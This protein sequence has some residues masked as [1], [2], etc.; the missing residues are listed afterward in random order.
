MLTCDEIH[1]A[2]RLEY[3]NGSVFGLT[4]NGEI[5]KTV[6]C[7]MIQSLCC[8]FKDVVGLTAV[9]GLNPALLRH[10]FEIVTSKLKKFVTMLAVFMD[11]LSTNR[12]VHLVHL[13]IQYFYF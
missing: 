6:L 3:F 9:T 11:N 5:A 13:V 12:W 2:K 4:E 8:K 7:F 10:N 1:T